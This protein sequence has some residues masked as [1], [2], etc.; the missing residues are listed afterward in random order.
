MAKT[1][2]NAERVGKASSVFSKA[3]AKDLDF[4]DKYTSSGTFN[5]DD[6]VK[7]FGASKAVDAVST[8]KNVPTVANSNSSLASTLK[9]KLS[10]VGGGGGS[11]STSTA[12]DLA[13][14]ATAGSTLAP[15]TTTKVATIG[16]KLKNVFKFAAIAF[17]V[18]EV[19]K[20]AWNTAVVKSYQPNGFKTQYNDSRSALNNNG[21]GNINTTAVLDTA[22]RRGYISQEDYLLARD[23]YQLLDNTEGNTDK[24]YSWLTE[25][26]TKH[27]GSGGIFSITNKNPFNGS[28]DKTMQAINNAAKAI[29]K[30]QYPN[31]TA[32]TLDSYVDELYAGSEPATPDWIADVDPNMGMIDVDDPYWYTGQEMADLYGIN[33]D[34][35]HYYDL[36]KQG[37]EAQVA[38]QQYA[39]EQA[40]NAA[41]AQDS[42]NVNQ[43][44]QDLSATKAEATIN[45]ATLG[46]RMANELLTN[47]EAA[48]N[49][50]G[51]QAQV[52]QDNMNNI[53]SLLLNNA[54]AKVTATDYYSTL[55]KAIESNIENL[56]YNDINK[57][58]GQLSLND[59][60]Y[61][62]NMNYNAQVAQAN[63][64]MYANYVQNKA[65]A[66]AQKN[67]FTTVWK[68]YYNSNQNNGTNER[69]RAAWAT[70]QTDA[71]L[72]RNNPNATV[73]T[74]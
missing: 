35:N 66:D 11:A 43:Y 47:Q 57:I 72:G 8:Y 27:T 46:A 45:G 17:G 71:Y 25:G 20:N 64:N 16:S 32:E 70:I 5:Y 34:V 3:D 38:A 48:T 26:W 69:E 42:V 7:L 65:A 59:S 24:W 51:V 1:Y 73:S 6:Y 10:S 14:G 31:V 2:V 36:I 37:T 53:N 18:Y 60:I 44:L 39:N 40:E 55:A 22:Y 67:A 9:S 63:A 58:G 15:E 19:G 56:Y 52:A 4:I 12:A 61:A 54:N 74:T 41:L 49:Y 62:A 13:V 29:A 33:Y 28:V 21:Y 23:Y 30:V 68:A 50:S